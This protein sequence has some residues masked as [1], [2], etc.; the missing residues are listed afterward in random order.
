MGIG[1]RDE[2]AEAGCPKFRASLTVAIF[3]VGKEEIGGHRLTSRREF[4]TNCLFCGICCRAVIGFLF[5]VQ[6]FCCTEVCLWGRQPTAHCPFLP[7]RSCKWKGRYGIR[8][9]AGAL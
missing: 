6:A 3:G 9:N 8:H 1:C 7:A 4:V 2:G 5:E